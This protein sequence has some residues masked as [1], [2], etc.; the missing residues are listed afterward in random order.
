MPPTKIGSF[1]YDFSRGNLQ[2]VALDSDIVVDHVRFQVSS[3]SCA[4]TSEGV[5]LLHGT[6]QLWPCRIWMTGLSTR[7]AIRS[8]IADSCMLTPQDSLT[9]HCCHLA[10]QLQ[11]APAAHAGGKQLWAPRLHMHLPHQGARDVCCWARR[12]LGRGRGLICWKRYVW[13]LLSATK[14]AKGAVEASR[15]ESREDPRAIGTPVCWGFICKCVSTRSDTQLHGCGEEDG[16]VI[17]G[18]LALVWPAVDRPADLQTSTCMTPALLR[19]E[20]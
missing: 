17:K 10:G 7:V 19:V 12:R 1:S 13:E 16:T 9:L 3:H 11:P 20:L 8:A 2:T 5:A 15:D 6:G 4:I 14:G 18:R